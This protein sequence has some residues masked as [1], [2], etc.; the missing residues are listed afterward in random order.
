MDTQ[1]DNRAERVERVVEKRHIDGTV[2]LVSAKVIGGE[3]ENLP[4][5]YFRGPQFIGT[6][7]ATCTGSICAY[8]S[9]V[10]PANTLS[11]ID[12]DLGP[13][14]DIGWVGTAYLL[15]NG[16][17]FLLVGR[18]SD[19]FGRR[20]M[21][22]GCNGLSALGCVVGAAAPSVGALVAATLLNGFAAA[23]Q[24]SHQVVLG[25]LV[26]NR[27]RGPIVTV[28]F[29][30]SLP[31]A[32]F[33]PAI[34]RL[35]ILNTSSA[36]QK[37]SRVGGWRW[38]F[39]LGI[40][41]SVVTVA[42][43]AVFYHPPRYE[44]L[45]VRGRTKRQQ[46]RALD[47]GG[48]ALFTAGMTLFLVGLSWGGSA[49]PWRSAPVLGTL[50]TGVATLVA[51]GLYEQFVMHNGGIMPPRIFRNVGYL[52]VVMIATLSS[53]VYFSLTVLW[54]TLIGR[55]FG[56]GVLEVGWQSSVVGGGVLLG[57]TLGG[58]AI[59]FVPRVKLQAVGASVCAAG[60]IAGLA[61]VL[62]NHTGVIALGVF[63]TAAV[64]FNENIA[65]PGV[66]LLFDACDIGLAAGALASIRSMG[67]AVAQALY[68]SILNTQVAARL[69]ADVG[70][71][72]VR[73]GL[74]ESS[75][76]A[77]FAAIKAADDGFAGVPGASREVAAAVARQVR[78][79][80]VASFRVVFLATIP[81]GFLLVLFACFVP[82]MEKYLTGNVA[83]RLQRKDA[84]GGSTSNSD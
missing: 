33:G 40:I 73:A 26:P 69:A 81:F 55:V 20:W 51:F 16:I 62:T 31:F 54:P 41:F 12:A 79:S 18:L 27:L 84:E 48:L 42:L 80:Y 59:S 7:V 21:V 23:G 70:P 22:L 2:D 65:F 66:T 35:F 71:A 47:F 4:A 11:L 34:A 36:D 63:A 50:V 56:A 75:L 25:E 17:G 45:H 53:M 1:K 77:L 6:V 37:P 9:W 83:R 5:G 58:L 57:Q 39:Y 44:Q 68:V 67:G 13:S 3:V 82:N 78:D 46:L 64:G 76:A 61:G 29:L 60:F 38:S 24:L 49:Y 30:S 32:V 74:P 10:M 52:A 28:V 72:A 43:Y 15:G 19:I 14:P 8:L